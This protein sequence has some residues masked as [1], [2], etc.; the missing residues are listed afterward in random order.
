MNVT[1][2]TSLQR[3]STTTPGQRAIIGGGTITTLAVAA[4]VRAKMAHK[5]LC[6]QEVRPVERKAVIGGGTITTPA[7][8]AYLRR[9][10]R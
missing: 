8:A 7:V 4:H 10:A 5:D 3:A 9:K 6:N 1:Q 2:T